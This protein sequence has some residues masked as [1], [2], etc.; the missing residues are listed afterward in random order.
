MLLDSM[1]SI[2]FQPHPSGSGYNFEWRF[3]FP[4]GRK[5]LPL[6]NRTATEE[7]ACNFIKKTDRQQKVFFRAAAIGSRPDEENI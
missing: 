7:G 5:N 2:F 4:A 1:T 3:G 6:P